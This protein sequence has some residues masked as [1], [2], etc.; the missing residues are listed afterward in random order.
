MV[1]PK[2]QKTNQSSVKGRIGYTPP[3]PTNEPGNLFIASPARTECASCPDIS[4]D[5]QTLT[6]GETV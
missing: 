2:V 5:P 3:S 6:C 4:P 1:T